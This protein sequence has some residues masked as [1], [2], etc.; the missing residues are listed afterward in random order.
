MYDRETVNER[1]AETR[2][3]KQLSQKELCVLADVTP[4]QLSRIESGITEN[5]S[6]D[7]LIRLSIALGVSSD[8]LLCLTEISTPKNY[9]ISQLGLSEGAVKTIASGKTDIHALNALLENAKFRELMRVLMAYFMDTLTEGF[10]AR[11]EI[12]DFAVSSLTDFAKENPD[13]KKEVQDRIREIRVSKTGNNEAELER[14]KDIFLAIVKEIK[15]IIAT[16]AKEKHTVDSEMVKKIISDVKKKN[17]K[18]IEEVT[19]IVA[20]MVK[21]TA[22][23]DDEHTELY[24]QTVKQIIIAVGNRGR[25]DK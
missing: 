2:K 24:R 8:Y 21:E 5:V 9:E 3:D 16:T 20:N 25:L 1:I 13:K 15:L 10:T 19:Q 17:P 23:L 14:I 11:N 4:T 22:H 6:S 7:V 18:S 12:M